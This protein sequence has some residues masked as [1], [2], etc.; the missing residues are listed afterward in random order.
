MMQGEIAAF[1]AELQLSEKT[2]Q[3]QAGELTVKTAALTKLE[4]NIAVLQGQ[5]NMHKAELA[6]SKGD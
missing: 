4:T 5:V 1:Q 2:R 6:A 3:D